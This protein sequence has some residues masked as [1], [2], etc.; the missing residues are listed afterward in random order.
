MRSLI[1]QI[2]SQALN[3]PDASYAAN[4]R[5]AAIA[6][7]HVVITVKKQVWTASTVGFGK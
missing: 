5:P 6:D 3:V 7:F 2:L 4:E 1:F